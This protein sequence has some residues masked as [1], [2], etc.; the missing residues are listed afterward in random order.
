MRG[1]AVAVVRGEAPDVFVAEDIDTL[2]WVLALEWVARADPT[3]IDVGLRDDLRQALL[4]ERWADAVIDYMH[5]LGTAV[6]VYDGHELYETR[7]VAMGPT[8][9]QFRPLFRD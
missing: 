7:D 5:H 4:D 6:D 8:E 3:H 1:V 2:H 9:L